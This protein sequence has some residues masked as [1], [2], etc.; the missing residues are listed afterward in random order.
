M[1]KETSP[2]I[3]GKTGNSGSKLTTIAVPV[4]FVSVNLCSKIKHYFLK[5]I[6][7]H[8]NCKCSF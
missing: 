6:Y 7:E 2:F 3:K 8:G 4:K 1:A 5:Q